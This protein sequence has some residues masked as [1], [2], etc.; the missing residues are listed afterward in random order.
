MASAAHSNPP[1]FS[2]PATPPLASPSQS[3]PRTD[4]SLS[5]TGEWTSSSADFS[6]S[7]DLATAMGESLSM[8]D[9]IC[10]S[11]SLTSRRPCKARASSAIIRW[12]IGVGYLLFVELDPAHGLAAGGIKVRNGLAHAVRE[13]PCSD[14][15]HRTLVGHPRC[16]HLCTA[17]LCFAV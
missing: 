16:V 10:A 17:R 3:A 14:T 4:A 13:A 11:G 7:W 12:I 1:G 5:L 15:S 2:T 6:H 9:G 8:W